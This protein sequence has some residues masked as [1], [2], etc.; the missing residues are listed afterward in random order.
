[1][2]KPKT[3]KRFP[4][5]IKTRM[6]EMGINRDEMAVYLHMSVSTYNR[7]INHNPEE[8]TIGNLKV[9]CNKLKI[10]K[11]ALMDAML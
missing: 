5:L 6:F 9:F 3:N 8:F 1:M 7:R 2:K 10:D 11:T 4:M